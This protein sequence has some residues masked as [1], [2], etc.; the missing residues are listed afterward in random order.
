[1]IFGRNIKADK[2]IINRIS[3]VNDIKSELADYSAV[4]PPTSYDRISRKHGASKRLDRG[5]KYGLGSPVD[6]FQ[7]LS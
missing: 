3:D 1:M 7:I 2:K 6:A 4:A 5:Q